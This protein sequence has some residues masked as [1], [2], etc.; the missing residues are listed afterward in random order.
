MK[1]LASFCALLAALLLMGIVDVDVAKAGEIRVTCSAQVTDPRRVALVVG[2]AEYSGLWNKLKNPANDAGAIA[3]RLCMLGFDVQVHK[4]LDASSF[5]AALR[6]FGGRIAQRVDPIAVLFYSGHG[7]R[8]PTVDGRDVDNYLIPINTT[9][10]YREELPRQAIALQRDVIE[11]MR[12]SMQGAGIGIVILDACRS[13][14]LPSRRLKDGSMGLAP[15]RTQPSFI[16]AFSTAYNDVADDGDG[17]LSPY[18]TSLAQLLGSTPGEDI[19]VTFKRVAEDVKTRTAGKQQPEFIDPGIPQIVLLDAGARRPVAQLPAPQPAPAP[20]PPPGPAV[21]AGPAVPHGSSMRP[22]AL[23]AGTVFHDCADCPEMVVIPPGDFLMGSPGNEKGHSDS[24]TPQ[25][26]VHL[27]AFAASRY[28]IT[29]GQWRQYLKAAGG[30]GSS[31]CYGLNQSMWGVWTPQQKPGFSWSNPGFHQDDDHPVVCVTR[32][33]AQAYAKWLTQ[34]TGYPYR[35]LTEAEFEYVIRART[36]TAHWW[37]PS[38]SRWFWESPDADQCKNVNAADAALT[39]KYT[40]LK[41]HAVTCDDGFAFTA[42]VNHFPGN[43]FKLYGTTGNAASW[44][45]DCWHDNY[46]SAPTDGSAWEESGCTRWVVRGSAWTSSPEQ[47]RSA[48]RSSPD[49]DSSFDIGLRLASN[50]E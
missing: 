30:S 50:V 7:S 38:S 20:R 12:A 4:D 16:V 24:E 9:V 28:S 39:G 41:W 17:M 49:F 13:N 8:G 18:T 40:S 43:E 42:P 44:T 46:I 19:S 23:S 47:L 21:A 2:N 26:E 1:S 3:R 5:D 25:H 32:Q 10:R 31:N 11:Q 37:P 36:T 15:P 45:A 33:E 14:T 29:V 22:T 48:Y 34:K 27:E 35:L 6:D